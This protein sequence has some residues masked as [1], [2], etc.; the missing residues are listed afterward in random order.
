MKDT[1]FKPYGINIE[2]EYKTYKFVGRDYGNRKSAN[3]G[4]LGNFKRF[5]RK[6]NEEKI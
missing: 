3:L 1:Y 4:W 2:Y 5:L 6:M